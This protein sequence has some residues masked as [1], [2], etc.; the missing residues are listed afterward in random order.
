MIDIFPYLLKSTIIGTA[1]YL[2]YKGLFQRLSFFKVNRVYLNLIIPVSVAIPFLQIGLESPLP[3]QFD[4]LAEPQILP[5]Q[6]TT[7]DT[8]LVSDED[9]K[10]VWV[11]MAVYLF[12]C[13]F[14]TLRLLSSFKQMVYLKKGA[15]ASQH[16]KTRVFESEKVNS[17]FSF[18][19]WVFIPA[20]L[21]PKSRQVVLQHEE[22]HLAQRHGIDLLVM[23]AWQILLWFHPLIY[24]IG[25]SIR[26]NHEYLADRR[27]VNKCVSL[28]EYL[29]AISE[30][31]YYRKAPLIQ[32]TFKS[33]T[34]TQRI[35]TMQKKTNSPI[36]LLSYVAALVI[37]LTSVVAF[38][39]KV[40]DEAPSGYPV[41]YE[42]ISSG[43]GMRI[44]PMNGEKKL[45]GGVDFKAAL[46]TPIYATAS[47]SV[48]KANDEGNWGNMVI[49]RHGKTYE[50]SYSH[51]NEI[52]IEQGAWVNKGDKIGT[53]GNTGRSV[54]PHLHYEIR[55]DGERVNPADYFEE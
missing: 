50:T 35:K 11:W 23:Q 38:S 36:R 48:T 13:L 26:L 16:H 14:M 52:L 30:I 32:H 4:N 42:R 51:M 21:S 27:M 29:K 43:F 53:V 40:T 7:P 20:D 44:H 45:H 37:V 15:S 31:V 22:V 55:K 24:F 47:G 54:G 18:L 6:G 12:G 28:A 10:V 39:V 33:N 5:Y 49:I 3:I 2:L 17:P 19:K 25:N 46:G 34:I 8:S 1:L 9:R 41:K